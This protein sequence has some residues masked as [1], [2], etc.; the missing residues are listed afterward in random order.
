[1][2]YVD[3]KLEL[4]NFNLPKTEANYGVLC[5]G[6]VLLWAWCVK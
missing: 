3:V 4:R 5:S 1:M 2:A 6:K